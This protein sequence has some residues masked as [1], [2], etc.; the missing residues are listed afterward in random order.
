VAALQPLGQSLSQSQ[1][2]PLISQLIVLSLL[3]PWATALAGDDF[4]G[5]DWQPRPLVDYNAPASTPAQPQAAAPKATPAAPPIQPDLEA[6]LKPVEPFV[7]E[8]ENRLLIKPKTATGL[9]NRLNN[10]QTVLFGAQQYNDAGQLITKLS[11]I[12]PEE[13]KKAQAEMDKQALASQQAN[14]AAM[15]KPGQA[16]APV[17]PLATPPNQVATAAGQAKPAK[18]RRSFWNTDDFDSDFDNDPFFQDSFQA[19]AKING[20]QA[21]TVSSAS[22]LGSAQQQ[23]VMPQTATTGTQAYPQENAGPS[24]LAGIAQGLAG[25]A[26]VVGG[27]AGASYL[28]GKLGK[29]TPTYSYPNN[30][31]YGNGVPYNPYGYPYGSPYGTAYG[32]PVYGSGYGVNPYG[33]G[34]SPYGLG[35]AAYGYGSG[36]TGY[37]TSPGYTITRGG[38]GPGT[39]FWQPYRGY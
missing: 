31:Y 14:A 8:I 22:A 2:K 1:F 17:K 5:A 39:P 37:N 12:F 15:S 24:R 28:N 27:I 11:E 23:M 36:Y 29:G 26:L 10:L 30:G 7:K 19:R 18:K 6:R 33:V 35:S 34:I 25:L 16:V 21:G 32:A 20:M 3:C 38:Y 13:A 9:V 4:A